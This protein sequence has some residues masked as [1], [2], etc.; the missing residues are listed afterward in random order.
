MDSTEDEWELCNDDGFIYKRKKRRLEDPPAAQAPDPEAEERQR[1]ERKR[2]LLLKLK[3]QYQKEIDQWEYLSS[4]LHAMQEKTQDKRQQEFEETPP[5]LGSAS[6][7]VQE[8]EMGC[9]SLVDE[10]LLQVIYRLSNLI[11]N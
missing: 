4:T 5:V 1:R 7:L 3:K 9:V 8:S 2:K 6:K 11:F 10:L